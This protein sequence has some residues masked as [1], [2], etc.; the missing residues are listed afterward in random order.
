MIGPKKLSTIREEIRRALADEGE[1]DPIA[2][3]E[4]RMTAAA[5]SGVA[6]SKRDEILQSLRRILETPTSKR[7]RMRR[8][9]AG[10]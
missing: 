3:L 5:R 6:G 10:K 7:T 8:E 9:T 2:W 1:G 4:Q